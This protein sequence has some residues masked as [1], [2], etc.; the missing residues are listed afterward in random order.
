K[1]AGDDVWCCTSTSSGA[2][3]EDAI[4]PGEYSVCLSKPGYGSKRV[5]VT[6][7]ADK[8]IQ[9]RLLSDRLLGY[10]WPKWC[11]AGDTVQFRV[12]SVAPYKLELW[13][14]GYRKEFVRSL[15][16]FDNHG[17]RAVMQTLPDSHFVETGVG[18]DNG[19]GLHRQ[20]VQA[21]QETGLYYFHARNEAG[22][23][24]SFPPVARPA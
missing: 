3:Y 4:A 7:A 12:H 13:R 19:F 8:P 20:T 9:F 14:Y 18:W 1:R 22:E 16:W 21:P 11:R 5:G 23:C 15:G 17:P 2:V 10:A 24:F 6:V